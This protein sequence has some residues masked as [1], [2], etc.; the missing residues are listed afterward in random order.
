M[1]TTTEVANLTVGSS[2]FT[3][4]QIALTRQVGAFTKNGV[5]GSLGVPRYGKT[6]RSFFDYAQQRF[7]LE[8]PSK[9]TDTA[10]VQSRR[11]FCSPALA[12][13][14]RILLYKRM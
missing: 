5:D 11:S 3:D 8:V 4:V 10:S 9:R 1:C 13:L 7:C 12:D 6:G 14:Y 2:H